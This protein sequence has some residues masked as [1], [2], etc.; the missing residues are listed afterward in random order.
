PDA[1]IPT[2]RAGG[3]LQGYLPSCGK[4][5]LPVSG[6]AWEILSGYGLNSRYFFGL[7]RALRTMRVSQKEYAAGRWTAGRSPP[8]RSS[9]T[10]SRCRSFQGQDSEQRAVMNAFGRFYG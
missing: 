6:D 3:K 1:M 10:R 2:T 4:K 5:L 9:F 7:Y 8:E